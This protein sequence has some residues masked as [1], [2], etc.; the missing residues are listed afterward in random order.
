MEVAAALAMIVVRLVRACIAH[1][2]RGSR[3]YANVDKART[4]ARRYLQKR[5]TMRDGPLDMRDAG[6]VIRSVLRGLAYLWS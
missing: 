3:F 6:R 4:T 1:R 2:A 5:L